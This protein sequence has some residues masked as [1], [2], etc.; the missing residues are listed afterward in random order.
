MTL[1]TL[2]DVLDNIPGWR[3]LDACE[4]VAFLIGTIVFAFGLFIIYK[5]YKRLAGG[6][7]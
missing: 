3:I 1:A 2:F 4:H 5:R 7:I 6:A